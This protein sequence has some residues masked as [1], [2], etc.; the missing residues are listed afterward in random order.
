MEYIEGTNRKIA[1][2][3]IRNAMVDFRQALDKMGTSGEHARSAAD[4]VWNYASMAEALGA[5]DSYELE[6]IQDIVM[7][8]MHKWY[9]KQTVLVLHENHIAIGRVIC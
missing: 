3:M 4:K 7:D 2:S 5:I 9:E 8:K 6:G 1:L